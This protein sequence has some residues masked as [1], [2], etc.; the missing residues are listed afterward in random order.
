M[1]SNPTPSAIG[2]TNPYIILPYIADIKAFFPLRLTP[3]CR[4]LHYST[5]LYPVETGVENGVCN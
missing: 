4:R 3:L 5:P 1:G 2:F